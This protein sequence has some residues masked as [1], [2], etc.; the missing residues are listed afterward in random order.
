MQD[1]KGEAWRVNQ[2]VKGKPEIGWSYRPY[3]TGD[4][5]NKR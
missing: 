4:T 3:I 2:S 1:A 5:A